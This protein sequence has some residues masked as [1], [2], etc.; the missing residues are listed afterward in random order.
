MMKMTSKVLTSSLVI[1][2]ALGLAGCANNAAAPTTKTSTAATKVSKQA[3]KKAVPS[4]NNKTAKGQASIKAH[5]NTS[6]IISTSTKQN[7][8]VTEKAQT[9]TSA[10]SQSSTSVSYSANSNRSS[11]NQAASTRTPSQNDQQVLTS[12]VKT[13]G[14]QKDGNHYYVAP[15]KQNSNYQIEVRN[16]QSGD[17]NVAHLTGIYQYDPT[18]NQIQKMNPITGNYSEN[19]A[20]MND[21]ASE[22]MK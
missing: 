8:V 10:N 19:Y 6:S 21:Q 20:G 9:S 14:V 4:P 2:T 18:T 11:Q 5:S 17:P 12:F 15:N 22:N 3:N 16:N 1:L 7:S 13:S